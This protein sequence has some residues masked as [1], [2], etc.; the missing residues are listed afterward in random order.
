MEQIPGL[1]LHHSGFWDMLYAPS[2]SE[3]LCLLAG[4]LAIALA[5]YDHAFTAVGLIVLTF[6]FRMK[7][8][9]RAG[10]IPISNTAKLQ[11]LRSLD[12]DALHELLQDELPRWVK[13]PDVEKCDWL[14]HTLETLWPYIKIAVARTVKDALTPVLEDLKPKLMMTELGFRGLDLGTAA[15]IINGIKSQPHLEEQV[16]MDVDLLIAT[17]NSDVVFAFGNST[18]RITMNVEL[19]DF[20][21]R[22]TF[23]EEPTINFQLKTMHVNLMELPALSSMFHHAIRSAVDSA[24]VWPNKVVIP[25]VDDLSKLEMEALAAN[26]PL[27]M[28]VIKNLKLRG[29]QPLAW[30]S[31]W[32][33]AHSFHVELSVGK[34]KSKSDTVC[35]QTAHDFADDT[36]FVLVLDPKTQDLNLT[37]HY[38]EAF[39]STKTIDSK[40]IHLD[41]LERHVTSKE[42]M[43]FGRDDKGRA[44]M[45]LVWYPFSSLSKAQRKKSN[46]APLPLE[47][48]NMGVVLIKLVK[49]E[50][51]PAMDLNGS[52]D[53]YVVF[54]VGSRVKQST[55]KSH[56]LNPIWDPPEH[57]GLIVAN[58]RHDDLV[59]VV[60][61]HDYLKADDE[62]GQVEISLAQ[63]QRNARLSKTWP[64]QN[65]QGA[66]TLELEWK[67][68]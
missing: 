48:A 57:F 8:L 59:V 16:V 36:F 53:P 66:I 58:D 67:C 43:A 2:V 29:V 7:V 14:N 28:L 30:V 5:R 20:L 45:D 23:T 31:R 42:L 6:F 22:G 65:G 38:K 19:S 12:R 39:G 41:H 54:R 3:S 15:P 49:C 62:I 26:K 11:L 64:L 52:S 35:G 68:F 13:F 61:D 34:E 47:I 46:E 25:L 9:D 51:L 37:L 50:R 60:M 18:S 1:R 55:I 27:G 17:Q 10:S 56:T 32:S 21:L 63:V 4:I 44:E 40:W 33:G 24:C